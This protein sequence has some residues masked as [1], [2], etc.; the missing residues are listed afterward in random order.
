MIHISVI[1][2]SSHVNDKDAAAYVAAQ[3]IQVVRDYYPIW[4]EYAMVSYI[5]KGGT[6]I[7][8]SWWL[9][10]LD[11]ADQADALGYHELTD[12]GQ[13][14]GK[15]FV[16]TSI[17]AGDNWTV[18]ASHEC[19][20]MLG[21]PYAS[22]ATQVATSATASDW[23]AWENCDAVEDDSYGYKINGVLMSDFVFP[24]WFEPWQ[25]NVQFDFMKHATAPL[26]ILPGGY[27]STYTDAQGWQQIEG[28]TKARHQYK[29]L[30]GSRRDRRRNKHRRVSTAHPP[31][32][33]TP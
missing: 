26:Q 2:Q 31:M 12:A 16:E 13:P 9:T 28:D 23:V 19:L 24:T 8:N 33:S 4:G 29:I 20:E 5:A 14:V 3:Q 25:K 10:L 11:D 30:K 7:P 22:I 21:D 6:P 27:I 1:N 18:T 15:V 17:K 32:S